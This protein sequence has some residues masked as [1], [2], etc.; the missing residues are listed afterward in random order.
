MNDAK[1]RADRARQAAVDALA[2]VAVPDDFNRADGIYRQA[3][4]AFNANSFGPAT[5]GFNQAAAQFTAA[6][7]AVAARRRQAEEAVARAKANSAQSVTH[8]TNVGR[9]MDGVA[10]GG[11]E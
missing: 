3:T 4:T 2:N 6:A 11:N 5:D 1:A 9:I 7:N 8:A 10:E